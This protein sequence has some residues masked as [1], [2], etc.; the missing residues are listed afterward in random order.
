MSTSYPNDPL[1]ATNKVI[2]PCKGEMAFPVLPCLLTICRQSQTIENHH[3]KGNL[4][5]GEKSGIATTPIRSE[6][7][8]MTTPE[9]LNADA[10]TVP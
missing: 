7:L 1:S 4:K 8:R 6:K 5:W 2:T 3:G 10:H 9:E